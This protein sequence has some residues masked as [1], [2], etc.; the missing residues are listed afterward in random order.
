MKVT[1]I[2]HTEVDV[3]PVTCYG[4]TDVPLK[5][6]FVE[7]AR[8]TS[9]ELHSAMQTLFPFDGVYSSPL[10]RCRRL[11]EFCGYSDAC[12]ED[13]LLELDFG[14]WEMKRFD[15]IADVRMQ[16][17]F[18]DWFHTAPTGG[19]S[20]AHQLTRVSNFLEA[21]KKEGKRNILVFTHAG[22][23]LCSLLH[24]GKAELKNL[25]DHQPPYGGIVTVEI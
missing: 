13:S 10:S 23:I 7:E 2:R 18:D 22:V 15:E 25:F 3:P 1:F 8:S 6:S 11:A 20:M 5:Q 16:E 19:E 9:D 4:K 12:L 21:R 14:E 17:W 24:A